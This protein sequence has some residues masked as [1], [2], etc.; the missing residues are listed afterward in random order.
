MSSLS[1][2]NFTMTNRDFFFSKF[3]YV[4]GLVKRILDSSSISATLSLVLFSSA[5]YE[6]GS[7]STAMIHRDW[8][9]SSTKSGSGGQKS[10]VFP[11]MWKLDLKDKCIHI[12]MYSLTYINLFLLSLICVCVC[13]CVCVYMIN[14]GSV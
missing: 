10:H 1:S 13:V 4:C 7:P 9:K 3:T 6:S 5:F 11:R 2:N 14:T 8:T 12:C